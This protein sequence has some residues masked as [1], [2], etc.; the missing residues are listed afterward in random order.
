MIR[1]LA[2]AAL[3]TLLT[4]CGLA[5]ALPPQMLIP[6]TS[7]SRL[8]MP[9]MA[10]N[11][12]ASPVRVNASA[13]FGLKRLEH[14]EF[15][16]PAGVKHQY[17]FEL[18]QDHGGG[19]R[20]W[21]GQHS[22]RGN[23]YRAV[24]TTGPTGSFGS[25]ETPE[26][27]FR[28]AARDGQDWL[29]DMSRLPKPEIRLGDDFVIPHADTKAVQ[30]LATPSM[31]EAVPGVNVAGILKS[32]PAPNVF[33]DI[34]VLYTTGYRNSFATQADMLTRINNL[35]A[36]ANTAYVDS[37]VAIT[38]RLV[39]T[40]Q[41]NYADAPAVTSEVALYAM[42]PSCTAVKCRGTAFDAGA[43]GNIEALR[44]TKGADVV[45]LLRGGAVNSSDGIAWI[46]WDGGTPDPG[47]MY[48]VTTGCVINC[49]EMVFIHEVGHNMGNMHDRATSAWQSGGTPVQ[50]GATGYGFGAYE[51]GF[52]FA[53]C[54]SGAITSNTF[55]SLRC[56]PGLTNGTSGACASNTQPECPLGDPDGFSDLMAYFHNST[57]RN[58]KFSN[59]NVLCTGYNAIAR[60]CGV[61][62]E[63]DPA[64]NT[65][66]SMNMNRVALSAIKAE[67]ATPTTTTLSSSI[68][69]SVVGQS[70][71]LTAQVASSSGTPGG[72]VA[73]KDGATT[74]SSCGAVTLSA[75]SAACAT[76]S[77]T[78]GTHSLTAVYTPSTSSFAASTSS[79]LT[80]V[81][82]VI[83]ATTTT[84]T[85]AFNPSY[86]TE[87][88]PLTAVVASTVGTPTG[89]VEFR[90]GAA[91]VAGCAS[92]A[93]SG[94]VASCPGTFAA[95]TH[96]L[97]AV[98][99]PASIAFLASTSAAV[100]QVVNAA[101]ATLLLSADA[102]AVGFG[103][104]SLS[105]TSLTRTV[106]F[107]NTQPG[108]V[109]VSLESSTDYVVTGDTCTG[110]V[111]SGGTCQV[112]VAFTPSGVGA[113]A[114]HLVVSYAGGGP[115]IVALTGA[116][117]RSLV[118]HYYQ[119]ILNRD[120]DVAGKA[121]WEG[122]A[123]RLAGLG[124]DVREAY[125]VMAGYFFNSPEYLAA[126][127]TDAQ[128]VTDLYNTFFNRA[129]DAG[130]LGFW[131]GQIQQGMPRDVVLISFMFS[132][133]FQSFTTAM[134]GNASARPEV[135]LVMDFFRGILNRLPE[136]A[137]FDFWVN[138]LKSAQCQ[139]AGAV[140]TAVDSMSLGFIFSP[141]YNDRHRTNPQFA[142]DM[143]YSFLRRGGDLGGVLF[144][145]NEL[146]SGTRSAN[147]VRTDFIASP[148]FGARVQAVIDAG[149]A[150]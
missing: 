121:F 93:L 99:T 48:S 134:F 120:P 109:T 54:G 67:P 115:T 106:T 145:I 29:V 5:W 143:Y 42:T 118:T 119:G 36:K 116:G 66:R 33:V 131:I 132:P 142:S 148:E 22:E 17:I 55:A 94:G 135:N 101:S 96:S 49:G 68:N 69:P 129:P 53:S 86:A 123:A 16:T 40:Q 83:A 9:D 37:E 87:A 25:I 19:I 44:A 124:A 38:L 45:A 62:G 72:T 21:V 144:W 15:T 71:T 59:P 139:G 3:A 122:E 125:Y 97:T 81:V 73:F 127:K 90:D 75:G 60:P 52:G 74:I 107:T 27:E 91:T 20:S 57:K 6:A 39:G 1:S 70:V 31:F 110:V 61:N 58:Y 8:R 26:G 77:L 111:A 88:L 80:Q 128:Y 2:R 138:Q 32:A 56:N 47:F 46:G 103:S 12:E 4:C 108:P 98:Y 43:F 136:T 117:E 76:S 51:Y 85:T 112:T 114:G 147:R 102:T 146:A 50:N 95:G 41:V 23:N 63:T 126:N 34:L 13:I 14:A 140:Y 105:T 84:L 113:I 92:V 18:A 79:A 11:D 100:S 149:C 150:P 141:E 24:I 35:V 7:Q 82:N 10:L 78:A 130:G 104:Q 65:A 133:E 89:T 137:A 64:A 30:P 28:I